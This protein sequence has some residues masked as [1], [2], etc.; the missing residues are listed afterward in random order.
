MIKLIVNKKNEL[1]E[2][3]VE[4]LSEYIKNFIKND[5]NVTLAIPG[6]SSVSGIF[7][8]LKEADINW[9]KV[10][11]FM[12]D[13]RL[14]PSDSKESNF[15][16]ANEYFIKDLMEKGKLPK[17]NVHPFIFTS[18]N[19]LNNDIDD[20]KRQLTS[21]KNHFDIVLLSSGEDGHIASLFP[22]HET[23]KSQENYFIST[24]NSPKVPKERMSA[25][26]DL[27]RRSRVAILLFFGEGKKQALQKF[28][29]KNIGFDKCPAKIVEKIE[30]CYVLTDIIDL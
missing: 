23:L 10:H 2:K 1:E 27:L 8:R 4:L 24:L 20:Y 14:V 7:S 3:A 22:K 29:D 19:S 16:L 21:L 28:L 26:A 6:G 15:K 9:D 5:N 30:E 13:E 17:E 12:I 11:I 25:S 18:F